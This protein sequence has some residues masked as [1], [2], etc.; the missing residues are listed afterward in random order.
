MIMYCPECE[1]VKSRNIIEYRQ[2]IDDI[3]KRLT[4]LKISEYDSRILAGERERFKKELQFIM[5][6]P[7]NFYPE[8]IRKCPACGTALKKRV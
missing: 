8:N 1:V 7:S 5:N 3:N 2:A 6:A 4:N